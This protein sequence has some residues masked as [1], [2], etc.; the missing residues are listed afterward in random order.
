[1]VALVDVQQ[2]GFYMQNDASKLLFVGF[3]LTSFFADTGLFLLASVAFILTMVRLESSKMMTPRAESYEDTSATTKPPVGYEY[4]VAESNPSAT[5][6][7]FKGNVNASLPTQTEPTTAPT[8]Q[9]PETT[10]PPQPQ[11]QQQ[12]QPESETTQ[13]T[14]SPITPSTLVSREKTSDVTGNTFDD[15]AQQALQKYAIE[16]SL[17]K[18]SLDGIIKSNYNK[19]MYPLG[20]QQYNIQGITENIV[21]YNYF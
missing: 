20:Q 18:A 12:Q 21:G 15:P 2:W 16:T 11:P 3:V 1:M 7:E 6:E 9:P 17:E 4:V 14:P 8:T 10:Q 5:K 19:F 13:I